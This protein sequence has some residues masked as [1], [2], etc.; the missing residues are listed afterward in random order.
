MNEKAFDV[1]NGCYMTSTLRKR[2]NAKENL[3]ML[4]PEDLFGRYL[5][6][7]KGDLEVT[8]DKDKLT[9]NGIKIKQSCF[10]RPMIVY[11]V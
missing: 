9:F 2:I 7:L 6:E 5:N 4:V 3:M 10:K 1:L 8:F 11:A